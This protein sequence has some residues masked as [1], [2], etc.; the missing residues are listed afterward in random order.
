MASTLV[1]VVYSKADRTQYHV[2]TDAAD[3]RLM[4]CI[5][6]TDAEDLYILPRSVYDEQTD[7]DAY[8]QSILAAL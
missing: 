4:P 8:I 7:F 2:I 5:F 3:T 1:G 6:C